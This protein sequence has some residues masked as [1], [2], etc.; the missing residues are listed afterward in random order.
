MGY[1]FK[2]G[3]SWSGDLLIVDTEDLKTMPPFEI[4]VKKIQI[5]RGGHSRKRQ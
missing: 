4:H 2:A 1:A 5:K 3:G